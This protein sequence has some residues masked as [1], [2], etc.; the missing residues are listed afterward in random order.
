MKSPL[1]A[2]LS[3]TCKLLRLHAIAFHIK[4]GDEATT[5]EGML[6]NVSATDVL[7]VASILLTEARN[8]IA[9]DD[10][11]ND[12]DAVIQMT[13]LINLINKRLQ[14]KTGERKIVGRM[15]I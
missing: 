10:D 5:V 7:G 14:A 1:I 2:V 6:T 13:S 4:R 11:T 3:K 9:E 15:P 12:V 8:R